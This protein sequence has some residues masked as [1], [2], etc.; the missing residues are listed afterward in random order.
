MQYLFLIYS[1]EPQYL[2]AAAPQRTKLTQ[3]FIAYNQD[4][5]KSGNYR[6]GGQLQPTSTATT[7]RP[8]GGK[9]I[10]SDGPYAETKEQLGGYYLMECKDLDEALALARRIPAIEMGASVE[11]R[12]LVSVWPPPSTS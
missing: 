9:V 3:D 7:L 11:V 8:Q 1:N 6:A 12:P 5:V 4:V 2:K 10:T